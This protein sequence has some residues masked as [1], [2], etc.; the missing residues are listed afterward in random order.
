MD[1]LTILDGPAVQNRVQPVATVGDSGLGR[2]YLYPE[3]Y[4]WPGYA[5]IRGVFRI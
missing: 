5:G 1:Q 3:L 2:G 4:K